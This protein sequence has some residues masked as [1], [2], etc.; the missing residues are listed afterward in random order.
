MAPTDTARL[1]LAGLVASEALYAVLLPPQKVNPHKDSIWLPLILLLFAARL[2]F[3]PNS[4][5]RSL[6]LL[7]A[8]FLSGVYLHRMAK[9][10]VPMLWRVALPGLVAIWLLAI[11]LGLGNS[12]GFQLFTFLLLGGP[13]LYP[14]IC[15]YRLCRRTA[16]PHL[17]LV[18]IVSAVVVA[19]EGWDAAMVLMLGR[20]D[21]ISLWT[22]MAAAVVFG[23]ALLAEERSGGRRSGGRRTS[24]QGGTEAREALLRL[25]RSEEAL[26][27]Q[28]RSLSL[29]YLA[30][31]I[32]HEFK[33]ILSQIT[34]LAEYGLSQETPA[35]RKTALKAILDNSGLA[36]QSVT[37]LLET[38]SLKGR[39]VPA[40]LNLGDSLSR[41]LRSV[42][43][44]YRGE[45]VRFVLQADADLY[46]RAR[47]G[48][49][50]QVLLNLIRNAMAAF[51][52]RP[53]GVEKKVVL[54]ARRQTQETVLEVSDNA[55]G[56]PEE[57][58]GTLFDP[59]DAGTGKGLGLYVAHQVAIRNG[60]QLEYLPIEGGSR[61]R[62][63]L[64]D[65]PG[66]GQDY[67]KREQ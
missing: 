35:I 43:A 64:A 27:A 5:A 36:E 57:L 15:L 30:A 50:M 6:L 26:L 55:G 56:I 12:V 22:S 32:V 49:L 59:P 58:V 4:F 28:D 42:K 66:P 67:E 1:L 7:S 31:G 14:L 54:E 60:G 52:K 17:L 65:L 38:L 11:F 23:Y 25:A 13:V 53:E 44:A 34:L 47:R 19:G 39:E 24:E 46:I 48:E 16:S 63:I 62:V 37:S 9:K 51:R 3:D 20:A 21:N 61:F 45:G 29:A 8:V 2:F 18:L 10:K 33:N 40:P 41:L